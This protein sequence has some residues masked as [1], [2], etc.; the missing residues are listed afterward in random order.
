MA[1]IKLDKKKSGN[2]LRIMKSYRGDDGKS[3]H[4][5]LYNLGK[6]EDYSLESL[7]NIGQKLYEL[8]G[9][10]IEELKKKMNF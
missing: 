6:A 3:K 7:K 8:G 2:Y 5:T 10:T 4:E 1:F 9:G